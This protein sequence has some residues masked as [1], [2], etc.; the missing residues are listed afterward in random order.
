MKH[1]LDQSD[2]FNDPKIIKAIPGTDAGMQLD[3]FGG[4]HLYNSLPT[5][6]VQEAVDIKH[7]HEI[8]KSKSK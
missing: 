6:T 3:I 2:M 1:T 5:E 8:A 4:N 7:R